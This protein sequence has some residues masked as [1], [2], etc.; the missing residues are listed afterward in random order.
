MAKHANYREN[1]ARAVYVVGEIN[2]ELV[3][4]LTPQITRLRLS[5]PEPITVYI[6]S[7][8]GSIRSA[9]HLQN[10]LRAPSQDRDTNWI[11]CV[12]TTQAKSAAAILLAA[13]DYAISYPNA[14]IMHHGSRLPGER[15]ITTE[16][17]TD[18]ADLLSSVNEDDAL[19]LADLMFPRLV[20]LH[21][22]NRNQYGEIRKQSP[23]A[24]S[25]A[26]CLA[27]VIRSK[28]RQENAL[29]VENALIQLGELDAIFDHINS[30]IEIGNDDPPG[31]VELMLFRA[32]L[33]FE[34][35]RNDPKTWSLAHR[36]LDQIRRDFLLL[37]KFFTKYA[38]GLDS[39]VDVWGKFFLSPGQ[40][41]AFDAIEER[42]AQLKH[43]ADHATP[44]VEKLWTLTVLLSQVLHKQDCHFTPIETYWLGL[45]DEVVGSGLPSKRMTVEAS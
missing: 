36:G 40:K 2:E 33:D 39:K 28:L 4:D 14:E 30:T 22:F 27:E 16:K 42:S 38:R 18:L 12:A 7:R 23:S 31:K 13:G 24:V 45:I 43:L 6:D 44:E 25:E 21:I 20:L 9:L 1:P 32:I 34:E 29:L 41:T 10:L 37:S 19:N 26:Q 35:R 11:I 8:G 5:G 17:A 3:Q 15:D